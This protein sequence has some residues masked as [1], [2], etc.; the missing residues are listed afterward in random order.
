[1]QTE[2]AERSNLD[3]LAHL[4]SLPVANVP[5]NISAGPIP[6]TVGAQ[7][8]P[9]YRDYGRLQQR[10]KQIAAAA[11]DDFYYRFPVR[12][13]RENRIDWIEGPSVKLANV[14]A[15]EYG[16]CEVDI[17]AIDQ[18]DGWI[19]YGR[20]VDLE[21]GYAAIR[22]FAQ[23]RSAAKLGGDDE[24]RRIEI[25]FA[26]GVSKCFRNIVVNVLGELADFAFEE[27][28]NSLVERIGKELDSYRAKTIERV[29]QRVDLPRVEAVIGRA[30]NDWLAP[31]VARVIAM[32]K[33]VTDGMASLDEKI[34]PPNRSAAGEQT[35][36]ATKATLDDLAT[37]TIEQSPAPPAGD[38]AD[39]ETVP[40]AQSESQGAAEQPPAG[41]DSAALK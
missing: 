20:F 11:G 7:N 13:R 14:I 28:R 21:S 35:E 37:K 41:D 27:A 23:R 25:A 16:N 3:E 22:P 29:S 38:A 12:N 18:G 10:I 26:I 8:L 2:T 24:G 6:L 32:M 15:R 1:M 17:R 5:A 19:L 31:D 33:A 9:R 4:T 39:S 40:P 36:V 30:A 34:P